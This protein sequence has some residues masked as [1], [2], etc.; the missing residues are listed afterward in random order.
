V[1]QQVGA[2]AMKA[3]APRLLAGGAAGIFIAG[4]IPPGF[5]DEIKSKPLTFDG[6]LAG[7]SGSVS[8]SGGAPVGLTAVAGVD[9]LI[10]RTNHNWA[11]YAYEGGG[12]TFG[13]TGFGAGVSLS[14]GAVW[15]TAQSSDYEGAFNTLSVPASALGQYLVSLQTTALSAA[16]ELTQKFLRIGYNNVTS[17]VGK[18][19]TSNL[20][21]I[22]N[23]FA[24]GL[25]SDLGVN[26]FYDPTNVTGGSM[27]FSVNIPLASTK[28]STSNI[29][30]TRTTFVQEY[31]GQLRF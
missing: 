18:V 26:L 13:N 6:A 2:I 9:F 22:S 20:Y 23:F 8:A 3:I 5:F 27:G 17:G 11:I 21:R 29:S 15:R 25:S 14:V 30:L 4:T 12:G 19:L 16:N 7:V 24:K 1:Q 10:G 31:S 28:G